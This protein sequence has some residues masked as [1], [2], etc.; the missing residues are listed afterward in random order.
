MLDDQ[1]IFIVV[2]GGII[3]LTLGLVIL[4][5]ILH[6]FL[7]RKYDKLL[8]KRPYFRETEL[9]AYTIWPFS[10]MRTMGYILLLATPRL[11]KLRRFKGVHLDLSGTLIFVILSRLFLAL[12]FIDLIFFLVMFY[13]AFMPK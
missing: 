11:V 7:T 12:L 8:F 4:W 10:L 3:V 9:G 13:M 1:T 6:F 5:H 2:F